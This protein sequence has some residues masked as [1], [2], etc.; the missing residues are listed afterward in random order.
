MEKSPAAEPD[1]KEKCEQIE[2][3]LMSIDA[4]CGLRW[5]DFDLHTFTSECEFSNFNCEHHKDRMC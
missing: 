5:S 4:V 3:P 1:V 2:C